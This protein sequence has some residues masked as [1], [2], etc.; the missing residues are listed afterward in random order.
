MAASS[1]DLCTTLCIVIISSQR[2][3]SRQVARHAP[4]RGARK[5]IAESMRSMPNPR[6]PWKAL[7]FFKT[8]REA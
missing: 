4:R 1:I 7:C 3:S 8:T 6:T 2:Y 5:F